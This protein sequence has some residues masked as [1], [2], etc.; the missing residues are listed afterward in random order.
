MTRAELIYRGLKNAKSWRD[1]YA[2]CRRVGII[3]DPEIKRMILTDSE[4]FKLYVNIL[5]ENGFQRFFTRMSDFIRKSNGVS[6]SENGRS[7]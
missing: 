1:L 6:P 3:D 7:Y 5:L 2:L 4:E